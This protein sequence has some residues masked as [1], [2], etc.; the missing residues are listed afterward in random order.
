MNKQ[1]QIDGQSLTPTQV[2]HVAYAQ[3][4]ELELTLSDNA[5]EKMNQSRAF[6]LKAVQENRPIYSINTGFGALSERKI[7]P[8]DLTTIQYNLIRSHCTG[9]GPPFNRAISRAIML[10]RANCLA[11]GHSGINPQIVQLILD[12]LNADIIPTIP[13]KGSVGASG[14]LAPL[15]HMAL[16]LI[17]EGEVK[18]Q[19]KLCPASQ[20]LQ[21]IQRSPACLGPKDGL[22]LINGTAVM[23]ALGVLAVHEARQLAKLSDIACALTLEAIRGTTTAFHPKLQETKPHPGQ[24]KVAA[25]L[26]K[27][28]AHSQIVSSHKDCP[29]IQDP[30]SLRCAP[31]VH[32][33]CRQV[34]EHAHQVMQIELN[35][36]TDNPLIFPQSGE[37]ISG[38]NF[39][40]ESVALAMDYLAMGLA[41]LC[42]ICER[43]VEKMINPQFSQLPAFLT[44]DS[45]PNS[46]LM[47]A[48]VTVAALASENKYLC[49]PASVDSIPTSSDKEDHVSMGVTCGRK[50]HEVLD[51][52]KHCLA[53]E[54]LCNTQA[55]E[56]LAPLKPPPGLW[57]TY[58]LIR[59]QVKPIHQDRAFY[60]D[61]QCIKQLIDSNQLLTE[62]EQIVGELQ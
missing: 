9:V 1:L 60:Q 23:T 33:A 49:H 2:H 58:Q 38:G 11:S 14:D 25:N 53:I 41:E 20:A 34:I 32:G 36:V 43:R 37:I 59:R 52:L 4:H 40:G 7:K 16:A 56:F 54:F 47:I 51:N 24:I 5:L 39:H 42:S 31:Q 55:M 50:L 21:G 62:C 28:L 22:A 17:G 29:R 48:H 6:V 10:L 57:A 35:S 3:A 45:G 46:G 8:Q 13:S 18:W 12:F 26:R 30:Y 27:L 15:A 61:I 44:A 19:E